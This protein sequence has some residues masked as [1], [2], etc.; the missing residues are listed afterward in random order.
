MSRDYDSMKRD[1]EISLNNFKTDFIDLY[2]F[3]NVKEEEYDNLL[4]IKWLIVPFR[5]KGAR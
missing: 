5:G 4:K 2:Q 1:V 3:H